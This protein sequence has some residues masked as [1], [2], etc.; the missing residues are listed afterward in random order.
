MGIL[1]RFFGRNAKDVWRVEARLMERLGWVRP[2]V[3]VQWISTSA[4]DLACPHCYSNAGKRSHGELTTTEAK[5]LLIDALVDLDR[6]TLV[7]AGGETLLRRDFGE[8]VAR[9]HERRIPWAIHTH[10]GHV[11]KHIDVFAKHPPVMAAI[12]VDGPRA[13]HDAFRGKRGSFDAALRAIAALKRVGVAEVVVGTTIQRAN[14]DLVC[15]MTHDVLASAADSW[16]FHLMTP[17]GRAG[18][19][20]ELLPT[21]HQLRRIAG[22]GRRLRAV[23]HVE[24]DNEWGSAGDDD[25]LYRDEAFACGAGRFSCVVSATGEVM[26]CT[27]TDTSES[28]GNIR[29]RSLR[30]I[31]E[32]GFAAFRAQSDDVRADD[33]DCWLNTR[34]GRS[35]RSAFAMNVFADTAHTRRVP[36]LQIHRSTPMVSS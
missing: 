7:I 19:H 2:P 5:E 30:T 36:L 21:R 31:W 13:Y 8:I 12:S 24:L 3:A 26:P 28:A 20:E 15:D 25:P 9:V 6:P 22:L 32:T 4:C 14:A 17:E 29:D 16:G 11:E 18:R 34:H 10:G 23:F 27:T 33:D 35:C 1:Q